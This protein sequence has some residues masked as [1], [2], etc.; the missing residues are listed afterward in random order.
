MTPR[1]IIWIGLLLILAGCA[2]IPESGSRQRVLFYA[3]PT[4]LTPESPISREDLEDRL[5]RLGY[6][7]APSPMAPGQ[8]HFSGGGVEIYLRPFRYPEGQFQGGRLRL[9]WSGDV[10]GQVMILDDLQAQ[11]LRLEPERIAGFEGETGAVLNPLRLEEAPPL[12]VRSIIAIEDR[13]FYKHPGIDPIGTARA[14]WANVRHGPG[15]QGGSTLTQQLARSL[16]LHNKKTILRKVQEAVLALELEVRYSKKQILEAYLNAVYWGAWGPMEIRG[17]REASRYYLGCEL[18]DADAAGIALLV[19]IIPAPNAY[20]PYNNP[21]RAKQRRDLVLR[22]LEKKGILTL[23]EARLAVSRPLP[24]KRPPRRAAEASYFL[25]AVRAEVEGRAPKDILKRPGTAVFTTMDPRDQA[26]AVSAVYQGLQD[27][28]KSHRRLRRTNDPL[29]AAL[30]TIDPATGE[31]RAL[32]GGRSFLEYPFN[33]AVKARRQPGSLFKPF[34]Y[35]AAFEH[36]RRKDGTF[37]TPA[38]I[39]DDEPIE[40]RSGRKMWRP[41]NYDREYRGQIPLRTALE[42]SLN[43]PTA[44]VAHEVGISRVARSARD[45]GIESPLN[46]VPSL[47]LG[48]S[49]VT[50]LE[51]TNAYAGLASNGRPRA[52]TLLRGILGADGKDVSLAP[53]DDPPGVDP[54]PAYLVT[55]LLQGVIQHGTGRSARTL[56]VR[57]EV[58]GKTGTTDDYHDAWFVGFTPRRATGVWVGFDRKGDVGLS[59]AA[60]ALPIWAASMREAEG[61]RGDGRFERPRGIVSVPIDSETGMLATA[62]C[63][64]FLEEEFIAGTEPQ[65]ECNQHG[66]GIIDRMGH[67]FGF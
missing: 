43:V 7:D 3:V 48:T 42:Q 15:A 8:Y 19:G 39:L 14:L 53:Q 12:L 58:A 9:R 63:P 18:E 56:G 41:Q 37:W 55:H 36:P 5:H 6:H 47:A 27:L 10:I 54:A 51:I 40:I 29:E 21:E 33:R 20:S 25:D 22:Q 49:E 65:E 17:A 34:V 11:D 45:L 28:E 66:G 4:A 61:P 2:R 50:L 32:V 38:T 46:E 26:A 1:R 67:L 44:A 60:A 59:G 23:Q 24:V 52:A 13:R 64:T 62:D 57:G 35:L 31:V 30:V 16:Y